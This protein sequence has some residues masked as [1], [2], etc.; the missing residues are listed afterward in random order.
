MEGFY[1]AIQALHKLCKIIAE[2]HSDKKRSKKEEELDVLK[3]SFEDIS[4]ISDMSSLD[5]NEE[6][7]VEAWN[8]YQVNTEYNYKGR[9]Q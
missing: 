7:V 3:Q 1:K 6:Y 8:S 5:T 9:D 4:V 2:K